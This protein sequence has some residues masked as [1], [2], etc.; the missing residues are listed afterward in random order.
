MIFESKNGI[1]FTYG[2]LENMGLAIAFNKD[3]FIF[4]LNKILKKNPSASLSNEAVQTLLNT[5]HTV[6]AQYDGGEKAR[7]LNAGGLLT[8]VVDEEAQ[9]FVML[10]EPEGLQLGFGKVELKDVNHKLVELQESLDQQLRVLLSGIAQESTNITEFIDRIKNGSVLERFRTLEDTL[11]KNDAIIIEV[12]TNSALTELRSSFGRS[13]INPHAHL[14]IRTAALREINEE[15]PLA[16]NPERYIIENAFNRND[17]TNFVQELLRGSGF[18]EDQI[19]K[20][21]AKEFH[22]DIESITFD[23][24]CKM[25]AEEFSSLTLPTN[26]RFVQPTR[27]SEVI[28]EIQNLEK[29][30]FATR[31][32]NCPSI[33]GGGNQFIL[34]YACQKFNCIFRALPFALL[35]EAVWTGSSV[36]THFTPQRQL[37]LNQACTNNQEKFQEACHQL[38][39]PANRITSVNVEIEVTFLFYGVLARKNVYAMNVLAEMFAKTNHEHCK[40]QE[41]TIND[42]ALTQ[43]ELDKLCKQLPEKTSIKQITLTRITFDLSDSEEKHNVLQDKLAKRG[44][45]LSTENIVKDLTFNTTYH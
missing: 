8:L 22:A 7:I 38:F 3:N 34:A 33:L 37:I 17:T 16:I 20:F 19:I 36:A 39:E 40:L 5:T 10:Q 28:V 23:V 43:G 25:S 26:C 27:E 14:A 24:I 11:C 35:P 21:S 42:K 44:I 12:S 1:F 15:I 4:K 18:L 30:F 13:P 45:T 32:P 31:I 6:L 9:G 29:G 2:A 41:V